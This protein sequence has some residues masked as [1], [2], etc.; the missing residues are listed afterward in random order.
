MRT[1]SLPRVLLALASTIL[2]SELVQAYDEPSPNSWKGNLTFLHTEDSLT[3]HYSTPDPD[4]TNW[5]GLYLNAGVG[6]IPEAGKKY[7]RPSTVWQHA[8]GRE[9]TV[10]FPARNLR[11]GRYGVFLN[12]R[13]GYE[14]LALPIIVFLSDD[15]RDI[16]VISQKATLPNAR[17]GDDY[18]ESIRHLVLDGDGVK[19]ESLHLGSPTWV[20]VTRD[21]NMFGT[22]PD[23]AAEDTTTILVWATRRNSAALLELTIPVRKKGEPLLDT[24]KVMS[25]NLWFGGKKV[26][27]YHKKQVRFLATSGVDIVGLQE[28]HDGSHARRLAA[29]LGW[30]YWSSKESVGVISRHRIHQELD[31]GL[32]AGG[33]TISLGKGWTEKVVVWVAHFASRPYGPHGLCFDGLSV[34]DVTGGVGRGVDLRRQQAEATIWRM[35]SYFSTVDEVPVIVLGDFNEPSHLD[36]VEELRDGH[37]GHSDVPW[38]VSK[39]MAEEGF[40]D[41]YRVAHPDPAEEE[42]IT[43]SPITPLHDSGR[44][45]PQDRIDFIYH[46]G[47]QLKVSD[48]WTYVAGEPK[49]IPDHRDN[50]WTSDHAAVIT[51][52]DISE[53][54]STW[55]A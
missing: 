15:G 10:H 5:I 38:P 9:G 51:V 39:R 41:S 45:E 14:W 29:A 16:E 49:N 40:I 50:E 13:D 52:Y 53:W 24:L 42:G 25:L 48:S 43:Y 1:F 11:P 2:F 34:N 23:D 36:Y 46:K 31:L 18:L 28:D 26:N 12:A 30:H 55:H 35:R 32:S 54:E 3:F 17:R 27:D 19:F 44:P 37:C 22:P 4:D 6:L 7:S 21:G 33:V 47:D 8:P 20:D